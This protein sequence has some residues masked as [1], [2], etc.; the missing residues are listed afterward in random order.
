MSWAAKTEEKR[1][2][3]KL[4]RERTAFYGVYHNDLRGGI[5]VKGYPYSTNH[6][7][8]KKWF[9]RHSNRKVRRNETDILTRA[10]HKKHFDLWWT[11]Y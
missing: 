3:E 10:E 6:P 2:L 4:Y 8:T 9:R 5:L 7:N 1:R 11:L